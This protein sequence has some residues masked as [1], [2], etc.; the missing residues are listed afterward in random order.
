MNTNSS[1][2][3][4]RIQSIGTQTIGGDLPVVIQSMV[5]HQ[6][7][8]T[9]AV[10][11]EII[12]LYESGCP[13]IRLAIPSQ[14]EAENLKE[15]K[16]QL[17]EKGFEIPLVADIHFT[18]KAAIIAANYVEKVRI[19]PGNFADKKKFES[20][21]YSDDEYQIELF[22]I[23]KELIP[24][25]DICKEKNRA[26]RIGV[27]QGSLSDRVLSYF[28]DTVEGMVASAKEYI[29]IF[30]KHDFHNISI[31][32]KSSNP[33]IMIEANRKFQ[34]WQI[35]RKLT[36]PLH[37]GVTEAGEGEDGRIKSALGIGTLLSQGIGDT[38]RVSLTED[39]ENEIPVAKYLAENFSR[40]DYIK[41]YPMNRQT[42]QKP[43]VL[44]DNR[45]NKTPNQ[46]EDLELFDTI[47]DDQSA[48]FELEISDMGKNDRFNRSTPLMLK[49]KA[50]DSYLEIR[51]ALIKIRASGFSNLI[52]LWKQYDL[53]KE[54][55]LLHAAIDFGAVI[56]E[57]L[58][59]GICIRSIELSPKEIAQ[60]SLDILQATGKRISKTEFI[61]CPSCGRTLF[62]LQETT[63]KIKE[64][65][66]HLDGLKIGI[67]G[68]I[69]NGPGEMSDADYGY[70]GS[71]KGKISLYKNLE[72]VRKNVPEKEAVE[73]LIYLIKENGDWREP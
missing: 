9:D 45:N 42:D 23:E 33:K 10:V 66:A 50:S 65:T 31:S 58:A 12:R 34:E 41:L 19:N 47:I 7:S 17:N 6:A 37:I 27:N 35:K 46:K 38:I 44:F 61:S 5:V 64:K 20:L 29:E 54:E 15:I 24:F 2:R 53:P 52:F 14:K 72:L 63:K 51:K 67:M 43:L 59:D 60:L 3:N 11:D 1:N 30:E 48:L 36:Y 8:D 26:V 70:V 16:L 25:I 73:A 62:N 49:C 18:P 39:P 57:G 21:N 55:L 56:L 69:V 13:I 71:G 4:H 22:R 68:C 40:K 28:G 32:L